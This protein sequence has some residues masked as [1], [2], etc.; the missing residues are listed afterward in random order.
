MSLK[1]K[2]ITCLFFCLLTGCGYHAR[3]SIQPYYPNDISVIPEKAESTVS[4][5][6]DILNGIVEKKAWTCSAHSFSISMK[7]EFIKAVN[8][9]VSSK[10]APPVGREQADPYIITISV[11]DFYAQ[12]D[13]PTEGS[14]IAF[15]LI[16]GAPKIESK[17]ELKLHVTVKKGGAVIIEDKIAA[18]GVDGTNYWSCDDIRA[19]VQRASE[20]LVESVLREL[21]KRIFVRLAM[22]SNK[23]AAILANPKTGSV[24]SKL[25]ELES[26]YKQGL[27][28]KQE[29]E[30]KRRN[31]LNKL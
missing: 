26:L 23:E 29:Y 28:T 17:T 22:V 4:G 25:K 2:V 30:E 5:N 7:D 18:Q 21:D 6:V 27:I 11:D 24:E 31:A 15:G 20:R 14:R 1:S 16:A 12:F 19:S 8:D 13:D 3:P 10:F 9:Y